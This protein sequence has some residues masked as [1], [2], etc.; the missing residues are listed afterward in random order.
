MLC[1]DGGW[2]LE[3]E[4]LNSTI[5]MFDNGWYLT[6]SFPEEPVFSYDEVDFWLITDVERLLI[7]KDSFAEIVQKANNVIK[8]VFLEP[9]KDSNELDNI[10]NLYFKEI[11][12][13]YQSIDFDKNMFFD[14]NGYV[15]WIAMI[16]K[17]DNLFL[18][19]DNLKGKKRKHIFSCFIRKES[20]ILWWDKVHMKWEEIN[21]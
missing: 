21:N 8:K 17:S 15:T 7:C 9:L 13:K 18:R 20:F 6:Y 1:T 5:L 16:N 19:I 10:A 14:G 2:S 11:L 4:N 3:M 12:T